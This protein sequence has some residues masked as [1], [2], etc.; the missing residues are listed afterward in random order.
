[1]YSAYCLT[2]GLINMPAP[3]AATQ[4]GKSIQNLRDSDHLH[5]QLFGHLQ[6][7]PAA[8]QGAAE[9]HAGLFG[10]GLRGDLQQKP[11]HKKAQRL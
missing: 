2:R 9:G 8:L 7:V 5:A 11:A 10:V 6:Q 1:M 3:H 4:S